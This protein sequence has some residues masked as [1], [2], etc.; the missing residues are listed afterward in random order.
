MLCGLSCTRLLVPGRGMGVMLYSKVTFNC[1]CAKSLGFS[2]EGNSKF[3]VIHDCY[4]RWSQCFMGKTGSVE[5]IPAMKWSLNVLI[6][7]S[8]ALRRWITG[9]Y[10]WNLLSLDLS[11]IW[12]AVEDPLSS[13]MCAGLIPL[14]NRCSCR[15]L[16]TQVNLLS[17]ISFIGCIKI[18]LLL[19]LYIT[20]T[21]L[22]Q[23]FYITGNLPVKSV[24]ICLLWLMILVN[25]VLVHC[26]SGFIG[27]SSSFIGSWCLV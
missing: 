18:I 23:L 13:I 25:I 16:K 14:A 8:T 15:S 11:S 10:S 21:Y 17:D 4:T 12:K 26:A 5:Y 2:L 9:N 19:F 7:R 1:A 3:N 6:A 27:C 24:A 20:D 22:F